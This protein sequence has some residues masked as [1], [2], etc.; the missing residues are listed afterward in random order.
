M[1]R[2]KAGKRPISQQDNEQAQR[3]LGQL[4]E[5]AQ[6]LHRSR[7]EADVEAALNEINVMPESAQLAL[8]KALSKERNVEAAD[9]LEAVYEFSPIKAVRKEAHRCLIGLEESRINKNK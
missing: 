5:I 7:S 6:Q 9:I 2:K 1:A 3:L 4:H 8:L